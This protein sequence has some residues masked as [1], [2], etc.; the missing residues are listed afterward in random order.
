MSL[1]DREAKGM[2]GM[3]G[4]NLSANNTATRAM[5]DWTPRSVKQSIQDTA[6]AVRL[7]QDQ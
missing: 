1:F 6:K 4:M 5:F 3:L 2:L 7:I